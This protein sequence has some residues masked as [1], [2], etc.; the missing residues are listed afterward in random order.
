MSR[1]LE[2]PMNYRKRQP[3]YRGSYS[4]EALE[5]RRLQI[6]KS[7]NHGEIAVFTGAAASGAFDLFRQYNDFYYL[8]GTE[9]PHSYLVI[10]GGS[11]GSSLFL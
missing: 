7:M 3:F 6:G 10:A 2:D 5:S 1:V 9:V 4:R 8:T 11:G